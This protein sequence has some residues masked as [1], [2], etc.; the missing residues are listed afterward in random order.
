LLRIRDIRTQE[1]IMDT[2]RSIRAA[3]RAALAAASM[4]LA[5]ALPPAMV[6]AA[7]TETTDNTSNADFTAGKSAIEQKNWG[8]AID[9]FNK[10]VARDWKN[11]DAHNYL[12]YAYRWSGRMDES[13]KHYAQALR[14]EPQHRGANEYI[15]VAYL[16][17]GNAAKAEEHL[18]RLESICGKNC[19]EYKDLAVAIADYKAGKR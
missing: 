11:A 18:V 8:A 10:V 19:D 14:L 13:F 5:F 2:F 15:G 9:A 17:V 12:G 1:I 6:H 4:V 7:G 16:K 3:L